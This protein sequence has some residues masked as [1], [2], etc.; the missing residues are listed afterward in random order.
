MVFLDERVALL[1]KYPTNPPDHSVHQ[2]DQSEDSDP[3]FLSAC[4][5]YRSR[6]DPRRKKGPM[7]EMNQKQQSYEVAL[8]YLP[9]EAQE[10]V[11]PQLPMMKGGKKSAS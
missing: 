8:A 11:E 5:P 10:Q 3:L 7:D 9:H 2:Y 1:A 6:V 4:V